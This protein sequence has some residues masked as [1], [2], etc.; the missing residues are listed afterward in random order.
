MPSMKPESGLAS[1][2]ALMEDERSIEDLRTIVSLQGENL[3]TRKERGIV[4]R[5]IRDKKEVE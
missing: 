3:G 1:V 5:E 2:E 4:P